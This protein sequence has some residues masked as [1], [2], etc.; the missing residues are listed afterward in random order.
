[1]EAKVHP[2]SPSLAAETPDF[3]VIDKPAGWLCVPGRDRASP[4]LQ[5]WVR[6]RWGKA[7]VCHRIDRGTSGL[8][9]VARN[10]DAHREACGWFER[11]EIKKEY[12]FLAEGRP[13]LPV[14]RMAEPIEGKPSVTQVELKER[15]VNGFLGIARPQ[16]GRRHQIRIH[17]SQAGHPIWGDL[18]YGSHRKDVGR[19]MLHAAVLV[20]PTGQRF[21]SPLP[22]DFEAWR[23]ASRLKE[24][25]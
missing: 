2:H 18:E 5:D 17:L 9:L 22:A 25:L 19:T 8:W 6:D 12:A 11:H 7:W 16:S 23:L 15:L 13:R 14:L 21:E 10:A 1:M 3:W 20:L 24:S 4:V